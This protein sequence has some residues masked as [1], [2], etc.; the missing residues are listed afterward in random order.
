MRL[1]YWT[2][3]FV[4][5]NFYQKTY[6]N[7]PRF[8]SFCQRLTRCWFG[9]F[10]HQLFKEDLREENFQTFA[11]CN[12]LGSE[13][14]HPRQ[15][16]NWFGSIILQIFREISPLLRSHL[17]VLLI[18]HSCDVWFSNFSLSR[19]MILVVPMLMAIEFCLIL[20]V[21]RV[22]L[23]Q[24]IQFLSLILSKILY[25]WDQSMALGQFLFCPRWC[26]LALINSD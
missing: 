7:F 21:S 3:I 6:S 4:S 11:F 26:H 23:C 12:G 5:R 19:C 22:K 9:H 25:F 17:K 16:I 18:Q 20:L 13:F 2:S 1:S 8:Q 15:V 14:W 24:R 10:Y